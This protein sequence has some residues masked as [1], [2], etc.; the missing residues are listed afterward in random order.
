MASDLK[1]PTSRFLFWMAHAIYYRRR[2]FLYPQ[3][4]LA[5][6]CILFTIKKLEF[7]T[8]RND[9]VGGDKAYHHVYLEFKKEFPVE[10]DLVVVV[11]SDSMEKNR[12]FVE[13]LGAKLEAETNLFTS[14][15]FKGD[16]TMMGRKARPPPTRSTFF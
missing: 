5:L 8:S 4:V 12:Q 14:V 2:W 10:D 11:E 13:R 1:S 15:F 16:L 9:L 6:V 7:L 3:I